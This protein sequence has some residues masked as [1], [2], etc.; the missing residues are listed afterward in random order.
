M[1]YRTKPR[2]HNWGI[3]NGWEAIEEMFKVISDQRNASQPVRMAKI[4]T[5]GDKTCCGGCGEIGLLLHCWWDSIQEIN[6][7]VSQKTGNRSTSWRPSY[8]T[9]G[10]IPKR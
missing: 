7:E 2:I 10:N 1:G 5:S 4:K 6:L 8:T 3:L 9:L